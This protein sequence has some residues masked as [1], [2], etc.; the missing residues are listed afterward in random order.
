MKFAKLALAASLLAS[1]TT[2]FCQ[3]QISTAS[4][5]T[6]AV[7][8]YVE[9][10]KTC[11]P[12]SHLLAAPLGTL[13]GGIRIIIQGVEANKCRIDYA[14]SSPDKRAK[15]FIYLRCRF[16]QKTIALQ[17]KNGY[18]LTYSPELNR[19]LNQECSM[20]SLKP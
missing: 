19:A 13:K 1:V 16:S 10:L 14:L 12:S 9:N 8:N 7:N 20:P 6:D 5:A 2:P 3:S 18:S 4:S 15:D 17:V 11:T